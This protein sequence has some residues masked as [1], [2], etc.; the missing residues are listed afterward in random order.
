[1]RLRHPLRG[2][3]EQYEFASTSTES[4]LLGGLANLEQYDAP[5]APGRP[6]HAV[7]MRLYDVTSHQWSIY[8]STVG[9]G[10]F[11]IPTVGRFK[12]GVGLFYDNE[13]YDG[14]P[15]IVRFTW[16]HSDHDHCHWEQAFSEDGGRTWEPN[17]IM[18]FTRA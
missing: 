1:M 8:W 17:W 3:N 14:R 18:E 7:A 11:G 9:S 2:S 12:R 6:I 13:E 10:T 4:P 16:T 15:I 5:D